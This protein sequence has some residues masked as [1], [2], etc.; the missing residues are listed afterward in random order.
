M[1]GTTKTVFLE[2]ISC[3]YV[4]N[5]MHMLDPFFFRLSHGV[6]I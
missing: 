5:F 3:L 4:E 6:Y 1:Q 2:G